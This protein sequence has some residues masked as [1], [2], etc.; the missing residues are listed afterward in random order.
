MIQE[1]TRRI[2]GDRKDTVEYRRIKKVTGKYRGIQG[3]IV[4]TGGYKED[5]G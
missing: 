1:D 5:T 3:W 2:Q 4:D